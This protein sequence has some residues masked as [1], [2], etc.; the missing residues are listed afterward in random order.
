MPCQ[1]RA[2]WPWFWKTTFSLVEGPTWARGLGCLSS[3]F[4]MGSPSHTAQNK[5]LSL[6]LMLGEKTN[7]NAL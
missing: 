7:L 5:L 1:R 4:I 3:C 2:K 6:C